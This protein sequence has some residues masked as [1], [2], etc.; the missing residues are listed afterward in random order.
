[1]KILN[2]HGYNGN[3]ENSACC[4]LKNIGCDVI[5]PAINYD[6]ES[7]EKTLEKL[8]NII[9]ENKPDVIT[10]TSYGGFF[11]VLLS[12]KSNLPVILVNPCFLPFIYLPR[13]GYKQDIKALFPM[14][15]VLS[16]LDIN[17]VSTIIGGNDEI[18]DT[19]DFTKNLLYNDRFVVFPEGKH[20]GAT[21]PLKKFFTDILK[22]I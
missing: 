5:S 7:P 19:H 17:K 6:I 22:N 21:L 10:G 4:V 20:S 15:S 16:E 18:I 2:I 14:F 8:Y 11:A 13:L 12:I 1:M 3:S 9:I